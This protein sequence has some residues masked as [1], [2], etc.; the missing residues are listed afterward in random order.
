MFE[1]FLSKILLK[2]NDKWIYFFEYLSENKKL[3]NK[4][5]FGKL[6]MIYFVYN[7]VKMIK[8]SKKNK[9]FNITITIYNFI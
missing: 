5:V 6:A 4:L 2:Y 7:A 3:I 9:V 8:I 1:Y